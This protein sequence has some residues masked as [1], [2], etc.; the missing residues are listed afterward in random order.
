MARKSSSPDCLS[1]PICTGPYYW[2]SIRLDLG[3]LI[4]CDIFYWKPR[5]RWCHHGRCLDVIRTGISFHMSFAP[6]RHLTIVG[7]KL[8]IKR[9]RWFWMNNVCD[10]THSCWLC[11]AVCVAFLSR[12]E[13]WCYGGRGR[14]RYIETDW[15][16]Q[17]T[18]E[19]GCKS[20][21][22]LAVHSELCLRFVVL[23]YNLKYWCSKV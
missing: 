1:W 23:P 6:N 21:Q 17:R 14:L 8:Y 5:N 7:E 3:G 13:C 16:M 12:I 22:V 11:D 19:D 20:N 10:D 4:I 2:T 9:A 18:D 15:G